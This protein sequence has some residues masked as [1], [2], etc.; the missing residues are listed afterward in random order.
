MQNQQQGQT[1]FINAQQQPIY[2]QQNQNLNQ[3]PMI[4]QSQYSAQQNTIDNSHQASNQQFQMQ[5]QPNQIL[6]NQI[7]QP[8]QYVQQQR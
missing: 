1:G 6:R 5:Q 4:N 8:M 2:H 7:R 3:N